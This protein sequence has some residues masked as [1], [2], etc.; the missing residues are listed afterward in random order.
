MAVGGISQDLLCPYT[1][2]GGGGPAGGSSGGVSEPLLE[3]ELPSELEHRVT[4]VEPASE[5]DTSA[6]G[7]GGCT[8]TNSITSRVASK[9]RSRL[10]PDTGKAPL[11]QVGNLGGTLWATPQSTAGSKTGHR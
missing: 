11:Q 3:H 10:V 1:G 7:C 9:T 4:T 2:L 6:F 8:G 5:D